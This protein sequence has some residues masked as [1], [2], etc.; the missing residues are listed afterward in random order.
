MSITNNQFC[1]K[2]IRKKKKFKNKTLALN[3]KPQVKGICIKIT[4]RTP[5]KPNSAIR[6]VAKVKFSTTK[7]WNVIFREKDIIYSNIQ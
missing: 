7:K 1:K 4:T 6:K 3:F 2:T 5:K